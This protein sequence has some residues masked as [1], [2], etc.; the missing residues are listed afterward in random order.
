VGFPVEGSEE[1]IA[2]RAVL[3]VLYLV[4]VSDRKGVVEWW[5]CR[6]RE[7]QR[8]EEEEEE[9]EEEGE[10]TGVGGGSR[11]AMLEGA[12]RTNRTAMMREAM[13]CRVYCD[14]CRGVNGDDSSDE[15]ISSPGRSEC[16]KLQCVAALSR[17]ARK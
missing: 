17:N 7:R 3:V 6:E 1:G 14:C 8:L 10:E 9:E 13:A 4:L 12:V 5:R 16:S 2:V 11:H 15:G